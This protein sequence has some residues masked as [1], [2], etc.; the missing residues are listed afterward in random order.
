M[1]YLAHSCSVKYHGISHLFAMTFM[2]ILASGLVFNT[3]PLRKSWG[4]FAGLFAYTG[5]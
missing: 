4:I 5:L 1:A 3:R 2:R